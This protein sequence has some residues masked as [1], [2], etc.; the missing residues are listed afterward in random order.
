V[1]RDIRVAIIGDSRDFSRAV[2]TAKSDTDGLSGKLGGLSGKAKA[3]FAGAGLAVGAFVKS[4][5]TAGSNLAESLSKS[6][7]VFGDQAATIEKWSG[8]ASTAFGQSKQQALDAASSFGNMFVQLGIGQGKAAEMSTAMT[9]LASDFASFHNADITEV[10]TAQQAAFR[11]EYDA[12]QRFVPTINAAAVEQKAL[13]MTGKKTTKELTAQEKALAVQALMME[14]AG[15]AAGDF[16]RTSDGLA[17]KQRILS[18]KFADVQAKVGQALIPILLKL[19]GVGEAIVA[20]FAGLSPEVQTAIG[21]VAGLGVAIFTIVKAVQAWTAV[22]AAL[23]AVMAMN[24]IGLIVIAIAA[25]VAAIVIAYQKV[26]WFRAFVDAAFKFIKDAIMTAFNWVKSNWPLLL[27]VLTGPIGL[28][29]LAITRNWDTIKAGATAAKD[30]IV[31]A[32]NALVGFVTGLPGKISSAAS[33]MFDGIKNAFRSAINWIID[34]WN[35]LSFSLPSIDTHIPGV[36]KI[37]GQTI[38]TPNIPRLHQGGM[39]RAPAG[40]REGLAMLLD[41]ERVLSPGQSRNSGAQTIVVQIGDRVIDEIVV[42]SMG[43]V[44]SRNGAVRVRTRVA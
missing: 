39:Y 12:L 40:Q 36:G 22:Q 29:V 14:G 44:E 35:N 33:G 38:S 15:D 37:G 25:F 34:G 6:N 1:A 16:A 30:W 13:A 11:G 2:A 27:A 7:T 17:N 24:P 10:L 42:D 20:F 23:N 21:V 41:G 5:V 32:F 28:A 26:D 8:T 19:V 3:A 43:R 9:E 18:A 4:S 31:G